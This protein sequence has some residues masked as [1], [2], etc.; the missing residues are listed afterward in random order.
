MLASLLCSMLLAASAAPFAGNYTAEGEATHGFY[1]WEPE[2][3]GKFPVII[4]LNYPLA[5]TVQFLEQ[6]AAWFEIPGGVPGLSAACG[7]MFVSIQFPREGL[8]G[9]GT[10]EDPCAFTEGR[11]KAIF[12][13]PGNALSEICSRPKADCS[14]GVRIYGIGDGAMM[15][16][17]G[18]GLPDLAYPIAAV[19]SNQQGVADMR[20]N[21]TTR[22][23]CLVSSAVDSY[24]PNNKRRSAISSTDGRYGTTPEEV[25][26]DQK[27]FPAM[28]AATSSSACRRTAQGTLSSTPAQ[29]AWRP[30]TAC[31]AS[32]A[33]AVRSPTPSAR[34]SSG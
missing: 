19:A 3:D 29:S 17:L 16:L 8:G 28:T 4:M 2:S 26:A 9:I 24:L 30:R 1:G 11:A 32:G 18:A 21:E 14:T 31:G 20:G 10:A 5:L 12:S 34:L 15:G 27:E 33:H 6:S 23:E 22:L 7:F 13:S 25:L